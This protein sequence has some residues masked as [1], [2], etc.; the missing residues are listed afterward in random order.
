MEVRTIR[1]AGVLTI[2]TN[3]PGR[4]LVHEYKTIKFDVVEE[5]S[6]TKYIQIS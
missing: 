1:T 6:A 3:H 4:N 2:Y 5:Q